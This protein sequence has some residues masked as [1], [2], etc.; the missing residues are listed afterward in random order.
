MKESDLVSIALLK[1]QPRRL[2]L[3]AIR[4][5]KAS[6]LVM[7]IDEAGTLYVVQID[8]HKGECFIGKL[9]WS[10][11]WEK[12]SMVG[13]RIAFNSGNIVAAYERNC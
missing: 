7:V 5:L 1:F 12:H 4:S 8:W 10:F 2:R 3:P 13:K 6:D 11:A 9:V